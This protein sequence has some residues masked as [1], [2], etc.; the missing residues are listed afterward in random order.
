[1]KEPKERKPVIGRREWF[2]FPELGLDWVRAKID[3]GARTS[4]L[5]AT[6]IR[7]FDRG[8]EE[9]VSFLTVSGLECEALVVFEK[10]VRSSNGHPSTRYFVE[11]EAESLDGG[12]HS[13]L[14][15]LTCREAMKCPLL[16]GRRAL[17][18]FLV[19]CS[20]SQLLGRR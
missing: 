16:L 1:M 10:R 13:L 6:G 12:K 11:V 9:W 20:R 18:N 14:V 2:R 17:T 5:H 3:T 8:G 4:S 7:A 19:D 15:S